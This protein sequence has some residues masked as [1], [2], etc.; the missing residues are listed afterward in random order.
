MDD[1]ELTQYLSSKGY[2]SGFGWWI[3]KTKDTVFG[4]Y[5]IVD[6]SRSML[7]RDG[8]LLVQSGASVQPCTRWKMVGASLQTMAEISHAAQAPVEISLLNKEKSNAVVVGIQR[9]DDAS[10]DAVQSMLETIPIGNTPVRMSKI[11]RK[12]QILT[13]PEFNL[14]INVM[15]L[16]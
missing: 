2:P 4:R 7:T 8:Q 10:L 5:I 12:T 16:L 1:D 6:N 13:T 3:G 15:L 11:P 9:D 14:Y